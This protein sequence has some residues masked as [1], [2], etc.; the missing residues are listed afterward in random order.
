MCRPKSEGGRRCVGYFNSRIASV[1]TKLTVA[2]DAVRVAAEKRQAYFNR[3]EELKQEKRD[4]RA[5]AKSEERS[6]TDEEKERIAAINTEIDETDAARKKDDV[7][8]KNLKWAAAKLAEKTH[9]RKLDLDEK[10]GVS[11]VE[12]YVGDRL[13]T[14]TFTGS[15]E[16]NSP[17]WHE[18]R[19]K[20]IG[21]SDVSIIMGTSPFAKE[22][23]LFALKTGQEVN[24]GTGAISSAMAL[25]NVYEPIIQRKFAENHPELKLWNTKGS[26]QAD[27]NEYQLA[28]IDGLYAPMG[29]DK[30]TGILEIKAVSSEHGWEEEPPIYY[31]QQALWYMDTFGFTE[32]KFA[33]YIN[34]YD[35]REY[36]ITAREGEME[37]IH[38]RVQGFQKRVA[39][40]LEANK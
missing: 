40:Y 28:N 8:L 16:A 23:K 10:L 39:D 11:P 36:T 29:S 38:S 1:S 22:E 9:A 2:T 20:G 4:I 14:A 37:E 25:G 19:A 7:E 18:Q 13:G 35:Y 21:G 34:Q 30:P 27:K 12:E 3:I 31:R 15:F 32:A 17:E 24:E 5:A 33:I 6:I 26:W